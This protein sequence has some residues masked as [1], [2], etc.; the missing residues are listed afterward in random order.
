VKRTTPLSKHS[1]CAWRISMR[2]RHISSRAFF[3]MAFALS[4]LA[5]SALSASSNSSF[6]S[7]CARFSTAASSW[8]GLG[9]ALGLGP[10]VS[11]EVS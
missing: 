5:V 3:A 11:G 1:V 7:A 8:L 2:S 6:S 10:V 4:T 9:L